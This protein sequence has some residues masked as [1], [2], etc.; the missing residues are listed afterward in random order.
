MPALP[1]GAT[2]VS[3]VDESTV[4]MWDAC[5]PKSTVK[6]PV[7]PV[8]VTLTVVKP[9]VEPVVGLTPVTVGSGT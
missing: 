1:A 3:A 7:K 4:T 8:P 2:A 6:G 5:P 9:P